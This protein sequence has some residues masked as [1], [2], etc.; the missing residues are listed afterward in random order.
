MLLGG[1]LLLEQRPL[2]LEQGRLQLEIGPGRQ[3][4]ALGVGD[5]AAFQ[6]GNHLALL[7]DIAEALAQLDHRPDHLGRYMT[8]PIGIHH[9]IAGTRT[10]RESMPGPTG[11]TSIRKAAICAADSL[12]RPSRPGWLSA[13]A[14]T[15][16]MHARPSPTARADNFVDIDI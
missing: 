16:C 14:Q 6:V 9:Y 13:A 1:Y 4:F 2:A 15:G 12:M 3:E 7:H 10:V 11:A 5:L 8:D